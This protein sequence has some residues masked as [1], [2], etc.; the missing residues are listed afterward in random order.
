M[1]RARDEDALADVAEPAARMARMQARTA[2]PDTDQSRRIHEGLAL[3]H[4]HIT[5]RQFGW[6]LLIECAAFGMLD[7]RQAYCLSLFHS[8]LTVNAQAV[9]PEQKVMARLKDSQWAT[10]RVRPCRFGTS[11]ELTMASARR[12]KVTTPNDFPDGETTVTSPSGTDD[13]MRTA[14]STVVPAAIVIPP[15]GAEDDGIMTA[16]T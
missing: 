16:S 14:S 7:H 13:S 1:L 11:C 12:R 8:L 3:P 15:T 5:H 9:R 4:D 2:L 10:A 6:G